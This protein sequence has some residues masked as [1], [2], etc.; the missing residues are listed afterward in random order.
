MTADI[1]DAAREAWETQFG[2]LDRIALHVFNS[3]RGSF[4]K[5]MADA[6]LKADAE[7]KMI[8]L[9]AWLVLIDKYDLEDELEAVFET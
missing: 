2:R 8:L 7:N 9:P 5:V 3:G 1:I 4:L 6:W